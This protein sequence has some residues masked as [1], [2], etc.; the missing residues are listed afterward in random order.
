MPRRSDTLRLIVLVTFSYWALIATYILLIMGSVMARITL[1][2][3]EI[4]LSSSGGA[5]L[6]GYF[7]ALVPCIWLSPRGR[8]SKTVYV[9][10]YIAL[11]LPAIIFTVSDTALDGSSRF[12][13]V[14]VYLL[15]FFVIYLGYYF[16]LIKLQPNKLT[17]QLGQVTILF[18]GIFGILYFFA[19]DTHLFSKFSF[20]DVYEKRL[21]L[22]EEFYSG[23]RARIKAY[24]ANW[25][26]LAIAPFLVAYGLR[27]ARWRLAILGIFIA[28]V[29]FA[30]S[31]HKLNLFTSVI[32]AVFVATLMFFQ[33]R[34]SQWK[35]PPI[36][37]GIT[38]GV[39]FIGGG[40]LI[41]MVFFKQ[42]VMTWVV[43]FRLFHN[44]GFLTAV[45]IEY[46]ADKPLLLYADSFLASVFESPFQQSYARLVG[47]YVTR[48]SAGNN[49]NANFLADGY[50]NLGY[51]GMLFSAV[52]AGVLLW[53]ADC[54]TQ[55]RDPILAA[56]AL[57]PFGLVLSNVPVHT[58]LVNNGLLILLFL[59]I[60][61][62]R[63]APKR[64]RGAIIKLSST[65]T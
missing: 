29:A 61:A 47:D 27:Y 34:D 28:L 11:L 57:V 23:A 32:T 12:V 48:Y 54:A 10:L 3:P 41:D 8:A 36:V 51:V 43:S 13:A 5:L 39:F 63:I 16:S 20:I 38:I 62:P 55:D 52:Q 35:S 50:V 17:M 53:L 24:L 7:L 59:L 33:K 19:S 26:G 22:R 46:F 9:Y 40:L 1:R 56:G 14:F 58:G 64:E 15:S 44:G 6:A 37:M 65:Y 2:L 21:E 45:Y 25:M 42:S 30:A 60:S 31:T 4:S 18:I 49:A